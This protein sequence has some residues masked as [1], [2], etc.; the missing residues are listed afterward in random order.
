MWNCWFSMWISEALSDP[1]IPAP[2][3]IFTHLLTD[4]WN[5]TRHPVSALWLE[6]VSIVKKQMP[7]NSG[8]NNGLGTWPHGKNLSFNPSSITC[9]TIETPAAGLGSSGNCHSS[10]YFIRALWKKTILPTFCSTKKG[11]DIFFKITPWPSPGGIR[12]SKDPDHIIPK[13]VQDLPT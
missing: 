9:Y 4:F 2:Q 10:D 3:I 1:I 11:S 6:I 13:S 8:I 5:S 7:L 12:T